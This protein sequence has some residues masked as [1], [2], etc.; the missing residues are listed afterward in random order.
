MIQGRRHGCCN[1][2]F[3]GCHEPHCYTSK[4]WLRDQRKDVLA[5]HRIEMIDSKDFK[6][7]ECTC[8]NKLELF[9]PNNY[10]TM[11]NTAYRKGNLVH[12]DLIGVDPEIGIII[13][14]NED[15][16]SNGFVLFDERNKL[17]FTIAGKYVHGVPITEEWFREYTMTVDEDGDF[18]VFFQGKADYGVK[19]C[20]TRHSLSLRKKQ[21]WFSFCI[22]H[23]GGPYTHLCNIYHIHELQ[24]LIFALT[25]EELE[26]KKE[27]AQ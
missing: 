20:L 14:L 26:L 13:G 9:E 16:F 6:M 10:D 25:G 18:T 27:V 24:N 23:P 1:R 15:R 4:S 7:E 3:A 22:I 5:G 21:E 19:F 12:F 17:S 8:E 2:I 11:K